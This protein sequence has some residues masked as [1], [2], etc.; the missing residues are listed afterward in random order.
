MAARRID[1]LTK[2]EREA[3]RF[4]SWLMEEIGVTGLPKPV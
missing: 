2:E 1:P 4:L 3:Q